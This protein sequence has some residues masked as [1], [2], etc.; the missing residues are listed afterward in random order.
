MYEYVRMHLF[1]F[2]ASHAAPAS[3]DR[4]EESKR[5]K[6]EKEGKKDKTGG[7]NRP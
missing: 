1:P 2:R 5:K 7:I 4:K 3:D 6:E